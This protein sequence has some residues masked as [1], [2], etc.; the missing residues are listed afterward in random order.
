M[1]QHLFSFLP[2]NLV[3][4]HSHPTQDSPLITYAAPLSCQNSKLLFCQVDGINI[5][6]QHVFAHRLTEHL[7]GVKEPLALAKHEQ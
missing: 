7:L 3:H 2:C 4:T 1:S 5:K 6:H